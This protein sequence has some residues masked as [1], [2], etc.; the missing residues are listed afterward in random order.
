[1]KELDYKKRIIEMI[2]KITDLKILHYI[3][4]IIVDIIEEK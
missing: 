1:M 3:Y 2:N 4:I